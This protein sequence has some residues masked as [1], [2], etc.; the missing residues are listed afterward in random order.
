MP[1]EDDLCIAAYAFELQEV[2]TTVAL[3]GVKYLIIYSLAVQVTVTQLAVAVVVVEVVGEVDAHDGIVRHRTACRPALVER[4]DGAAPLALRFREA[5]F[6]ASH[7]N[8]G[9]YGNA[10]LLVVVDGAVEVIHHTVVLYHVTLM[11]K[12][13]V[14]GFGGNDEV[15]TRPVLPVNEVAADGEGVVGIILAVGVVSRE[16][17]HDVKGRAR[18]R[19]IG[20]GGGRG[21]ANNLSIASDDARS[22][23]VIDGIGLQTFPFLQVIADGNADALC[24]EVVGRI[25][26]ASVVEHQEAVLA[27]LGWQ[28]ALPFS[29][30]LFHFIDGALVLRQLFPPLHVLVFDGE[31]RLI[32]RLPFVCLGDVTIGPCHADVQRFTYRLIASAVS[33]DVGHPIVAFVFGD[34]IAAAPCPVDESRKTTALVCIPACGIGRIAEQAP[35]RLPMQQV[36]RRG[37]PCLVA[38]TVQSVLAVIDDVSHQ[39]L[40]AYAEHRRAVNFVVVVRRGYHHAIFI[41]SAYLLVDAVHDIGRDTSG[42]TAGYC[43]FTLSGRTA[44][45]SQEEYKDGLYSFHSLVL[46]LEEPI[47]FTRWTVEAAVASFDVVAGETCHHQDALWQS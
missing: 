25:D 47:D 38:A 15:C 18:C 4:G 7:G 35:L 11:C 30:F 6:A 22:L 10:A 17:E 37:E 43:I 5:H 42:R 8:A 28:C 34:A 13:L 26:A 40:L 39:P 31:Q 46:S 16:V 9:S 21:H 41:R 3:L 44:E 45:H 20:S 27:N 19:N 12:H 2:A 32:G 29:L 1:I 23:V 33:T 24:L 14:V 36:V